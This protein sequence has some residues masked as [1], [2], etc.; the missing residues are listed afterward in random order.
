M[1]T[2]GIVPSS[3]GAYSGTALNTTG[4]RT[5]TAARRGS[6]AWSRGRGDGGAGAGV[7]VVVGA[8]PV[9]GGAV[10]GGAGCWVLTNS[11]LPAHAVAIPAV[12]RLM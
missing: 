1:L 6:G 9:A 8:E 2:T 3:A 11:Y 5:G 10:A 12:I 7:G 4:S